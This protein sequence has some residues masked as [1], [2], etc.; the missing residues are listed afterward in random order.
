MTEQINIKFAGHS[1]A[2]IEIKKTVIAIDPWLEGNPSTPEVLKNPSKVNIIALT[3]GHFDHA[4][5][6]VRLGKKHNSKL[7]A[8]FELCQL[9]VKAGYPEENVL[10]MN[11]GGGLQVDDNIR[12]DLT[13]ALHSNSFDL[14]LANGETSQVYAGEACGVVITARYKSSDY[15]IYHAGDTSLFSDMAL[16]AE[17]FNP[18]LCLLPIG[19]RFT[20]GPEDAAKAVN[21]LKCNRIIPIHH[22]TFPLLTGTPEDFRVACKE[23]CDDDLM[24]I[25]LEPGQNFTIKTN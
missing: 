10:P 8:T 23:I 5:D 20:M 9:L 17:K 1:A 4:A 13:H 25:N 19:D 2:F 16:I 22:S 3:H 7:C 24:L 18:A 21:L 12:I 6:V 11:K 14:P 15:A